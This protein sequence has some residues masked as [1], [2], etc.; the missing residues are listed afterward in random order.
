MTLAFNVDTSVTQRDRDA[1]II[2]IIRE[3]LMGSEA[4]WAMGKKTTKAAV[5]STRNLDI[6]ILGFFIQSAYIVKE[7]Y[8]LWIVS[9]KDC[10]FAYVLCTILERYDT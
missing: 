10:A 9:K 8:M 3:N 6:W 5:N 4:E 2:I 1:V 7:I